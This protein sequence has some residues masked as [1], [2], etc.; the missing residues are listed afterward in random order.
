MKPKIKKKELKWVT[1][2][3]DEE[4]DILGVQWGYEYDYSEEITTHEGNKFVIDYDKKGRIIGIE[5][6]D[7]SKGHK[8]KEFEGRK[9][10]SGRIIK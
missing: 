3:Y 9:T 7:W 8:A 10:P 6:F 5:I 1:P 2:S 4:N